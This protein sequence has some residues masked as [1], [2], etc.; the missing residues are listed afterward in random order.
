MRI[1]LFSLLLPKDNPGLHRPTLEK[2]SLVAASCTQLQLVSWHEVNKP[3]S[4]AV[5]LGLGNL[6]T[7]TE[8]AFWEQELA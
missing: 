1:K 3:V 7:R 6:L 2:I 8:L 5:V 4:D